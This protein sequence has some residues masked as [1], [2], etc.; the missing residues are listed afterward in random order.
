VIQRQRAFFLILLL[1]AHML[2]LFGQLCGIPFEL[3]KC[4]C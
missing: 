2:Q 1:R 4:S 3:L